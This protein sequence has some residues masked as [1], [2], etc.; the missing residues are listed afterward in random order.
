MPIELTSPTT[1]RIPKSE[2]SEIVESQLRAGLSYIN[3]SKN[4]QA[5]RFKNTG[6]NYLDEEDFQERLRV[7]QEEAKVCLLTEDQEFWYTHSGLVKYV[8]EKTKLPVK[9]N[10]SYPEPKLLAWHKAPDHKDRHYQTEA[11]ENL[12]NIKHG[13]VSM[14]T[15]LGKSHIIALLTKSL[16]LKTVIMAPSASITEQ[17]YE[18]FVLAFGSKNVGA[19]FGGKKK[20]DK[21]ITIATAQSLTRVKEDSKD[22]E[23]FSKTEVFIA[24]ESH[25]CPAE[26]LANVCFGLLAKAPYRFFF[27]ATQ[28]RG[29]GAG[30][31]LD[32]IIGP[33]VYTMTV[34]EGVAGGWLANPVVRMYSVKSNGDLLCDDPNDMTRHHVLYNPNITKSVGDICN[35]AMKLGLQ[36]IVLIDEVE[37]FTKLL[38]YLKY[39][40]SFAHG[41]LTENKSKV[42]TEFH[43]SNT[44]QQVKDF[45]EGK[46]KLL[47]GTSCISTGTD[48]RPVK[49]LVYWKGGRSQVDLLQGVGRGT[50]VVPGKKDFKV[51]DFFVEQP[52]SIKNFVP[53]RHSLERLEVYRS[54]S[55]SV[56]IV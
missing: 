30:V 31:L 22:W 37:Q 11:C 51:I 7:L 36:T 16:G 47:V 9:I 45:N 44:K 27:S 54:I 18:Q 35:S 28:I 29:D 46:I 26:T 6:R 14:G 34:K 32:G 52:E 55:D 4:F 12:L 53:F 38:P 5:Q 10:F 48:T 39:E 2:V 24:D 20:S 49:V 56:K 33:N 21:L 23:S 42:P 17:L 43:D 13:S 50:R 25:L 40:V 8:Q 41:T 3:K 1:L 15:G 19:F